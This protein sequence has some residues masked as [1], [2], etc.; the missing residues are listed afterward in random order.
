MSDAESASADGVDDT[1]DGG[2][3]YSAEEL[4]TLTAAMGANGLPGLRIPWS[5][6]QSDAGR[7]ARASQ[8]IAQRSLIARG[9]VTVQT[10]GTGVINPP[11]STLL[12]LAIS[13]ALVLTV[14]RE[15]GD[16]IESRFY[17]AHAGI[18]VEHAT[19]WLGVHRLSPFATSQL[20]PTAFAFLQ[21]EARPP[22]SGSSFEVVARLL[23]QFDASPSA[24]DEPPS[25]DSPEMSRLKALLDTRVCTAHFTVM[26]REGDEI[27]GGEL[28]WVDAGAA[29]LWTA[30]RKAAGPAMEGGAET[31]KIAPTDYETLRETLLGFLPPA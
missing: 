25:S 5:D 7:G 4:A 11:H 29:G 18:T 13:P 6:P 12:D 3:S 2:I 9:V 21:L 14:Q 30:E 28:A 1:L 10:D 26:Y 20:I 24:T 27:R 16:L 23:Q 31:V 8:A 19:P 15:S 17:Y 22:A